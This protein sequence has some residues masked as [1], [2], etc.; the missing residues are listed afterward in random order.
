MRWLRSISFDV[1]GR[2]VERNVDG[3]AFGGRKGFTFSSTSFI[4]WKEDRRESAYKQS[5]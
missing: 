5:W 2:Y 1:S 4:A 3:E